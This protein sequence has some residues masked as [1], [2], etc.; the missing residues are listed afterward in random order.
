MLCG[1]HWWVHEYESIEEYHLWVTSYF[2]CSVQFVLLWWFVI[3]FLECCF[4]D[5]FKTACNILVCFPFS[6]FT[7]CFVKVQVVQPYNS[8]DMAIAWKN[9][10]FI[11]SERSYFLMTV[12]LSLAFHALP[13]HM[14]TMLSVDEI[15]LPR[16]MIQST[17]SKACHLMRWCHL[18]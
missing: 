7:R 11:S 16:Y 6:F 17:D 2:T 12:S 10:H 13:M 4:K 18:D 9:P 15:L 5:L 8:T 1:L 14:L 3:C